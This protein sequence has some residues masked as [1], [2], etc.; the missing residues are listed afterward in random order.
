MLLFSN[1]IFH[2]PLLDSSAFVHL[3]PKR[4]YL[5]L[6]RNVEVV[7]QH[8]DSRERANVSDQNSHRRRVSDVPSLDVEV[9]SASED[10]SQ[11]EQHKAVAVESIQNL[12]S[13]LGDAGLLDGLALGG[14]E[15]GEEEHLD[16]AEEQQLGKVEGADPADVGAVGHAT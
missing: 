15:A 13:G 6:D 3:C 2:A 1:R 9:D 16:D 4:K 11:Q 7:K 12:A 5:Q 14:V 10:I 8:T